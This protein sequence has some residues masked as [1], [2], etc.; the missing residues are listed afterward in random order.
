MALSGARSGAGDS[1]AKVSSGTVG[2][3]TRL[4]KSHRAQW[5]RRLACQSLIG[6]LARCSGE[7]PE[8]TDAGGVAC[9]TLLHEQPEAGE[10][11]QHRVEILLGDLLNRNGIRSDPT[12][13]HGLLQ[14]LAEGIPIPRAIE[15]EQ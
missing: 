9:A 12:I 5:G 8:Q 15:Q 3:A 11:S 14:S 1:P 7:S 10:L 6:R 13:T 4:P 2:Q